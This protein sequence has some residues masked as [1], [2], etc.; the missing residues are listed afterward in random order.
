MVVAIIPARGGSKRIP[1]KNIKLF[2]GKPMIAYAIE[3]AKKTNLFDKIIVSTDSE[4][5]AVISKTYGADIPFMRPYKLAD[6]HTGT[7][8]VVIHAIECLTDMNIEIEAL[9]CIYPTVPLLRSR[10]IEEGYSLYK[11]NGFILTFS[12]AAFP[13]P[14]LRSYNIDK[15]NKLKLNWPEYYHSRSQDLPEAYHDAGQFYWINPKRLLKDRLIYSGD[16]IPVIIPRK[17]AIDIDTLEDW[18]YAE[19]L[20]TVLSNE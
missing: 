9:C 2:A 18:E 6:D 5:I 12:V 8:K 17:Y 14:I 15:K 11:N 16:A 1:Q 13:A 4:K 20:Y 7:S 19:H 3:V 10:S